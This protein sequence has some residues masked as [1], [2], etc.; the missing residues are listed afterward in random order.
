MRSFSEALSELRREKNISQRQAAADLGISQALLSHYENGLREPRLEFVA[1]VCDY[2][3]VS[4][5]YILGRVER[6]GDGEEIEALMDRIHDLAA[7]ADT[8]FINSKRK[9][10]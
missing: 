5:D 4:A 7:Y 10:R 1:R 6:K 9:N 3:G 8:V 2:Y